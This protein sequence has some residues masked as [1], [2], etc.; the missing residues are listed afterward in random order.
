LECSTEFAGDLDSLMSKDSMRSTRI[1]FKIENDDYML[2]TFQNLKIDY[3][4]GEG[5]E[6]MVYKS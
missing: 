3:K 1:S 6:G 2:E 5:G 4:I